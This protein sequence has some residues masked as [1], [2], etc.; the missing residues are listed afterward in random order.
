MSACEAVDR[1]PWTD[2]N[3]PACVERIQDLRE[4]HASILASDN[5]LQTLERQINEQSSSLEGAQHQRFQ[6]RETSEKL[7]SEQNTLVSKQDRTTRDLE[8]ID[9]EQRISLE[10]EQAAFLDAQMALAT[11]NEP[12]RH[13]TFDADLARLQR[14]LVSERASA[15]VKVADLKGRIEDCFQHYQRLWDDPNLG[16]TLSSYPDYAQ[17][18]DDIEKTGL[19]R[20][21]D[22]WRRRLTEWSGQD[23][24]PLAH[25]MGSSLDEI[26]NRLVPINTI[27]GSLPFGANATACGST[28]AD[29]SSSTS[30]TSVASWASCRPW[31]PGSSQM[32]SWSSGSPTYRSSCTRSAPPTTTAA[33][34]GGAFVAAPRPRAV[35]NETATACSMCASTSRSPP[36]AT[37]W[38]PAIWCPRTP[39][40][41]ESQA[42]SPRS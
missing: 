3:V 24:V 41:A 1:V 29:S 11:D 17:I 37:T 42:V 10:Q 28:C 12:P 20:R 40:W 21:R 8:R 16:T 7:L 31:R 18:F 6:F 33:C 25:A 13:T 14:H 27:L 23:L 22:E 32:T 9:G 5:V 26:E 2:I 34:P 38:R 4:R 30:G 35:Q 39:H 15:Q 36:S 19:H